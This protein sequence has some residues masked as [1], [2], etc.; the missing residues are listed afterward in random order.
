MREGG[1]GGDK[2]CVGKHHIRS[3]SKRPQR[4][5]CMRKEI[6]LTTE[7]HAKGN[8]SHDR[9]PKTKPRESDVSLSLGKSYIIQF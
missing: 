9:T 1:Y 8:I 3:F 7:I 2:Y 5:K 4:Q 6:Y